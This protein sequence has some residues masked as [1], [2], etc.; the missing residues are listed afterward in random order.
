MFFYSKFDSEA[1]TYTNQGSD[2]FQE[3]LNKCDHKKPIIVLTDVMGHFNVSV[4]WEGQVHIYDSLRETEKVYDPNIVE[5]IKAAY[6]KSY[7][8]FFKK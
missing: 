5:H 2:S 6:Q 4:L 1:R 8:L 7:I 3:E